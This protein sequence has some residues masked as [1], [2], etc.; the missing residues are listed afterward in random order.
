[1]EVRQRQN[2]L[3]IQVNTRFKH[4]VTIAAARWD[5][6]NDAR[7]APNRVMGSYSSA[8]PAPLCTASLPMPRNYGTGINENMNKK[9]E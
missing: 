7:T 9:Q 8:S 5:L 4:G 3:L 2:F 1:M 6:L